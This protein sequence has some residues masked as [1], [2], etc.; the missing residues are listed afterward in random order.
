MMPGIT[1]EKTTVPAGA[2]VGLP[3]AVGPVGDVDVFGEVEQGAPARVQVQIRAC[4]TFGELLAL[5]V[6]TP[7]LNLY[8]E[9]LG[10][11]DAIRSGLQFAALT[12]DI[13]ELHY[14]AA[15]ATALVL[16]AELPERGRPGPGMSVDRAYAVAVGQA[17]TRVFGVAAGQA[18][19]A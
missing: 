3:A 9:E 16:G 19:S 18:V 1:L 2:R 6:Y 12:A 11:D 10:D 5:L 7:G 17:V 8:W 14:R 13:T 15:Y 4:F